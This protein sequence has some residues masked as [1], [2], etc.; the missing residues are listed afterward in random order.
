M[1]R[2]MIG[3]C[4]MMVGV[5]VFAA[6]VGTVVQLTGTLSAHRTDGSVRILR[7]RSDVQNGDTLTTQT[8]SFAQINFTDG[9]SVTLRP[10]TVMNLERY[11]YEEK[12]PQ[13][14]GMVMRLLRG[15]LRTITGLIGKRGDL[16]AYKI[17]T[18]TVTMGIR[19][20]SGDT[21]DCMQDCTGVTSTSGKLPPGVYHATHNGIYIME[22][23]GGAVLIGEKEFGFSNDPSKPPSKLDKDPGLGIEGFPFPPG[24]GG[25]VEECVVG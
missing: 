12:K 24:A 7:L 17:R 2:W 13:G 19:G 16:D 21:L 6:G 10:N 22:T 4:F 11:S 5:G 14:D 3:A 1:F 15:G 18:S 23:A 9:S 25:A 8:A 20:S